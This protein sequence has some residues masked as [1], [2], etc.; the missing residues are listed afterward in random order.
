M[1]RFEWKYAGFN[2]G[3][4]HRNEPPSIDFEVPFSG[5]V[6]RGFVALTGFTVGFWGGDQEHPVNKVQIYVQD[7]R[8][9][10]NILRFR[11]KLGIR[12]GSNY[13]DDTYGGDF[14]VLAFAE[15]Q[16]A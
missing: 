1:A 16:G 6:E 13:F 5:R 12:D 15:V 2:Y 14:T 7:V 9:D 8:P 10:G 3:G 4:P 11:V